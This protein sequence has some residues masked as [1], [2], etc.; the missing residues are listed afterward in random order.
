MKA[1]IISIGN[2]L[3]I[4]DTVN[5]NAS[6]IG[7]FLTEQGFQVEEVRTITDDYDAIIQSIRYSIDQA[8][9]VVTTGGLGPTHDD[10]TKKAVADLFQAELVLNE[11]VLSHIKEIFRTRGLLFSPSNRDQALVPEGF[12]VLFNKKGTAPG[13]WFESNGS[14]LAV[15]PGV[16]HEMKYLMENRVAGKINDTFPRQEFHAVRYLK[17][18]GVAESTLSDEV[19][20]DLSEYLNN[21]TGIAFLPGPAGVTIRLSTVGGSEMEAEE[22]MKPAMEFIYKRAGALIYGE[23]RD[24]Q[25]SEILGNLLKKNRLA[26]AAAESCTGGLL[27]DTITNIPGSSEYFLGG[28]IAYSNRIKRDEL[29]IEMELIDRHGAVSREVALQMARGVAI[30]FGADIGVSATGIAGPGG[31]TKEK[32]VGMVWMGFYLPDK[33]FALRARFTNDRI[34]NKQRTVTVMLE[35]IRR[36]LLGMNSFPY[37][38]NPDYS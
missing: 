29:N 27:S 19:I 35:T 26:L 33:H 13:L 34:K 2:E 9:L 32:P 1:H 11:R 6:W 15:L 28:V 23:G 36:Q 5:T 16:P 17:T 20:G 22:Q 38:L 21:G 10:I 4:G 7:R 3:L 18:A 14:Y 31:G 24:V 37:D 12:E 8:D 30:K 25:V